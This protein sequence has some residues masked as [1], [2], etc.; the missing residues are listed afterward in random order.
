VP[1]RI[2]YSRGP[3]PFPPED[4][5]LHTGCTCAPRVPL[6]RVASGQQRSLTSPVT[7][8][9]H[10]S[11]SAGQ[12]LDRHPTFQAGHT[13]STPVTRSTNQ[14]SRRRPSSCTAPSNTGVW[15]R[16]SPPRPVRAQVLRPSV[17]TESIR[18]GQPVTSIRPSTALRRRDRRFEP[19]RARG[20]DHDQ[21][22]FD[23][24]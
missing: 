10:A 4:E 16:L 1:T 18:P 23:A 14:S 15:R 7:E 12:Y 20:G 22:P 8:Y 3:P 19:V 6:P 24:S 5:D 21:T 11:I 13:G 17:R 2:C 9:P